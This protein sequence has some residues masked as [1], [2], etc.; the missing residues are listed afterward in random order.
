M[1][2]RRWDRT[3][4]CTDWLQ[5][6]TFEAVSV[7]ASLV[8]P[9]ADDHLW[10][11]KMTA[12]ELRDI[13]VSPDYK[14]DLGELST[15]LASIKQER[16]IIYCLAKHLWKKGY[17]FRLEDKRKDL[18]VDGKR[19]EFKYSFDC[20]MARL[21]EA[22]TK[23]GKKPLK[24]MWDDVQAKKIS[25]SWST[26]ALIYEDMCIKKADI[27]VWIIH[28]RDLSKLAPDDLQRVC[29]SPEQCK[30]NAIHPYSD[31]ECL[32]VADS[33]LDH[34]RLIRPF[35]VLKEDI[36]AKG[37]FPSTYHLRICDFSVQ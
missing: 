20:D 23:Y 15:Y 24:A 25:K 10:S 11:R 32:R 36:E 6:L 9:L 7:L 27:F 12:K 13:F 4:F 3:P 21:E 2:G 22:L 5:S 19:I 26:I 29:W 18:V 16:P 28:A 35:S 31:R 17:K 34:M 37:D 14:H 30:Y 8:S 33:F 1:H